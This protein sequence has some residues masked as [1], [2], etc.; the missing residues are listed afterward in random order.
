MTSMWGVFIEQRENL[1]K[2]IKW[3]L[4]ICIVQGN[5]VVLSGGRLLCENRKWKIGCTQF[6]TVMRPRVRLQRKR[7]PENSP[8][9]SFKLGKRR[10]QREH[11]DGLI[12]GDFVR[13]MRQNKIEELIEQAWFA[14]WILSKWSQP[15]C[16]S[17]ASVVA[18]RGLTGQKWHL[19]GSLPA[20][21]V[22]SW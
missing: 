16:D 7:T 13:N 22:G 6:K 21:F 11:L 2:Y 17:H 4:V 19:G 10:F 8:V 3:C 9:P 12:L 14:S 1:L 5:T 15:R 20:T 18:W